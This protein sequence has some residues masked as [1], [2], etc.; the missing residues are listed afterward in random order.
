MSQ[1]NPSNCLTVKTDEVQMIFV[2]K[3]KTKLIPSR[4]MQKKIDH[5]LGYIKVINE[6]EII[7]VVGYP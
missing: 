3:L 2:L 7:E 1:P 6:K 4:E 5:L